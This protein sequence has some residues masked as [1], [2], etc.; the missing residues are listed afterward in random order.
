MNVTGSDTALAPTLAPNARRERLTSV[1]CLT[2]SIVP[3]AGAAVTGQDSQRRGEHA[4][5]I[6]TVT[7]IPTAN[8]ITMDARERSSIRA[9][10]AIRMPSDPRR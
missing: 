3:R 6:P 8:A 2:G 10:P 1:P 4:E 7:P 5:V 9:C